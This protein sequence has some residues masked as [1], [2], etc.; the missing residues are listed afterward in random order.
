MLIKPNV[1]KAELLEKK[2]VQLGLWNSL[3]SRITAEVVAGSGYD[4]M[5]IDTEHTHNELDNVLSLLQAVSRYDVEPIVRIPVL[6]QIILKKYMDIGARSFLIPF[7]NSVEEC[8]SAVSF[9][10]Y[11]PYGVRGVALTHRGNQYGRVPNYLSNA[12]ESICVI[13][14]AET[15][16]AIQNVPLMAQVEGIDAIFIG[17]G[18]LAA[19]YG[20]PGN[21]SHPEVQEAIASAL[22]AC[23]E[24]GKA[25]GILAPA[26]ADA[27]RYH[28][29]GF[30]F[31]GLGADIGVLARG[32]E[33]I[34]AKYAD[35][36]PV[37]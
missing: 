1:L 24:A 8:V 6:D 29:M 2:E 22:K 18:D 28:E 13:V 12:H 19:S 25:I 16:E 17:P 30:D 32:V 34:R 7:V 36:K 31:I 27:R 35:I 5:L 15:S 26:E 9:T 4:W 37:K 10:R 11:P 21:P 33:A 3:D 14:Q 20:H 23:K